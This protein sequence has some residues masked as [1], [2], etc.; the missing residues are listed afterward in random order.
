MSG[1]GANNVHTRGSMDRLKKERRELLN[2]MKEGNE[3][4]MTLISSLDSTCALFT[5]PT[6]MSTLGSLTRA[7][8]TVSD[9]SEDKISF[10]SL[11]L[12]ISRGENLSLV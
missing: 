9:V 5:G 10:P 2:K 1:E 4:R 12:F 6:K 3:N 8:S 11:I 7:D